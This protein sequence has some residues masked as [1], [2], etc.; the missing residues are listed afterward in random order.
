MITN[1]RCEIFATSEKPRCLTNLKNSSWILCFWRWNRWRIH[2]FSFFTPWNI[3]SSK[4]RKQG[5]S[6]D[7]R[8]TRFIFLDIYEIA[9]L[10][11]L[12]SIFEWRLYRFSPNSIWNTGWY[13]MVLNSRTKFRVHTTIEIY[14]TNICNGFYQKSLNPHA[15]LQLTQKFNEQIQETFGNHYR[16]ESSEM[17]FI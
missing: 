12:F 4:S 15:S 17:I 7:G 2:F 11:W 13:R 16:I 14:F 3:R 9:V 6:C 5:E 1:L 10:C 8:S